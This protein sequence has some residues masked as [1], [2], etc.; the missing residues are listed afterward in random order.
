MAI[1]NTNDKIIKNT[2]VLY[3]RMIVV[4]IIGL[5][6][7]RVILQS[8]GVVDYGIYNVVGSLVVMFSYLDSA[9]SLAVTRFYSYELP[10]GTDR[11]NIVFNTSVLI[12]VAFAIIV[13]LIA[14]TIG[15][16]LVNNKMV[17]P[18]DRIYAANIVYQLSIFTTIISILSV[19]FNASI[20]SHED[21]QI[22][23]MLSL[24]ESLFKLIVAFMI[25][26]S[27]IDRLVFYSCG[28]LCI[29]LLVF[30]FKCFYCTKHYEPDRFK[31]RFSR[32]LFKKMFSF[33]GWN[34][35]GATAGV[36]VGQGLNIVINIFF[37]P[38]VNAARGIAY[39]V[40]GAI[41]QLVTNINM[42]VNP[43]IVKRYST[44]EYDSMFRLVFFSSK[45]SFLLLA[46]VSFP[47]I[48]DAPYILMLW[49]KEV[50]VDA[51][52]FTRLML[53][54]MMTVSLT[55]SVN[56]C[57][58]A[59]GII[60]HVQIAESII[61]LL[62]IPIVL[63]LFYMGLPAY[64][65]FFS[66]IV[67]SILSFVAK[68]FI[69]RNSIHYPL[70]EYFERVLLRIIVLTVFGVFLYYVD[71]CF[72]IY[73][74]LGVL[75]KSFVNTILLLLVIWGAVLERNEKQLVVQLISKQIDKIK[76]K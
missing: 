44:G 25:G 2:A 5:Y 19:P 76:K 40:Q 18:D 10:H 73:T 52:L 42:A 48:I 68:L 8:L 27:P 39:Q 33:V 15:L 53:I 51:V 64:T 9:L 28:L 1:S 55:Y 11:V 6:S 71:S 17:I 72:Q 69:L 20:T 36:S 32:Q 61:I 70:K 14:D 67:F 35:L 26:I 47:I 59:S 46:I 31:R 62:N 29:S 54:Y 7:S 75:L 38:T 66:M 21:M 50:P 30:V 60:K 23:A 12:Q 41:N 16:W 34:F 43:Q 65:S 57:A 45:I 56:M 22:Y 37:G 4:L 3:V 58:Q 74:F 49:L 63:L 24:V 13:F